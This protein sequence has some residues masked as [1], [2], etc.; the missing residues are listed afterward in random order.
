TR[1]LIRA[2]EW[3]GRTQSPDNLQSRGIRQL[4]TNLLNKL[5]IVYDASLLRGSDIEKAQDWLIKASEKEQSLA[6]VQTLTEYVTASRHASSNT[7]NSL[8][9]VLAF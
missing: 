7:K 8:I 2:L 4:T 9:S 1:L 6:Q 5:P 3:K